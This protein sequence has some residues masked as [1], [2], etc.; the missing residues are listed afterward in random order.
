MKPGDLVR[1]K[2]F[3]G[4]W[5]RPTREANSIGYLWSDKGTCLLVSRA[6][7]MRENLGGDRVPYEEYVYV[8]APGPV[9]AYVFI[10][11]LELVT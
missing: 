8:L 6:G 2:T 11:N 5:D 4:L 10:T 3:A 1:V 7:W 9:L